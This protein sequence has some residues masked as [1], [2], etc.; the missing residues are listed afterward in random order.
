MGKQEVSLCHSNQRKVSFPAWQAT[1]INATLTHTARKHNLKV[2]PDTHININL[3]PQCGE[4]YCLCQRVNKS[5]SNHMHSQLTV[6]G[7]WFESLLCAHISDKTWLS[8]HCGSTRTNRSSLCACGENDS[9]SN[10][11]P[12]HTIQLEFCHVKMRWLFS[13]IF[14]PTGFYSVWVGTWES[15]KTLFFF[16]L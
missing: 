4:S 14:C 13:S 15:L 16:F 5:D 7:S 9:E 6:Y 2:H 1:W 12:L 3:D 8:A 10:L 11:F